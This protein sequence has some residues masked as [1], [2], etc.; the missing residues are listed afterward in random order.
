ML[1]KI[2]TEAAPRAIGPYSQAIKIMPNQQSMVFVSGQLPIDPTTGQLVQADI[3]LL[4]KRVI[5][6]IAAILKAAGSDLNKVVRTD[7]FLKDL[8]NDFKG[9]NTEY[10]RHFNSPTPPARQT[11]Q[12]ADLPMGSPIEISCVALV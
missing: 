9:M 7:V 11:I 2:D 8:K 12:V 10:S 6:N 4:T 3:G 1:Q 5:D